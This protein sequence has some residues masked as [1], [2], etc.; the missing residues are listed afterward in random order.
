MKS[1]SDPVL[2]AEGAVSRCLL[3]EPL[4]PTSVHHLLQGR[5]VWYKPVQ[6]TSLH[7]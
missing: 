2:A 7:R 3:R 4:S 5:V 6:A 1:P